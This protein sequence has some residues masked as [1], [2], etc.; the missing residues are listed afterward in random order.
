MNPDA[1]SK[2][3]PAVSIRLEVSNA[4]NSTAG[5]RYDA[6]RQ[7]VRRTGPQRWRQVGIAQFEATKTRKSSAMARV[8]ASFS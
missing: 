1:C 4:A 3:A 2:G 6:T 5:W 8:P 7:P